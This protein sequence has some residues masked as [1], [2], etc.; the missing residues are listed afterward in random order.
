MAECAVRVRG[1]AMEE[2]VKLPDSL[3]SATWER[4]NSA[5]YRLENFYSNL[6][7]DSSERATR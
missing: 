1:I 5:K 2:F 3:S 4:A 7:Q 6:V